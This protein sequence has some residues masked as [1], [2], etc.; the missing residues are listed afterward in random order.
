MGGKHVQ[1]GR[2]AEYP[3]DY[4]LVFNHSND[5]SSR[6]G[7]S[8]S[9]AQ[10]TA[11][12]LMQREGGPP[13]RIGFLLPVY[14]SLQGKCYTNTLDRTPGP[15]GLDASCCSTQRRAADAGR[16]LVGRAYCFCSWI[17]LGSSGQPYLLA[18]SVYPLV[19]KRTIRRHRPTLGR[20][21]QNRLSSASSNT[22]VTFTKRTAT[23]ALFISL[24]FVLRLFGDIR[25]CAISRS[26]PPLQA[27]PLPL[28]C[29]RGRHPRAQ[30]QLHSLHFLSR[31]DC[32]R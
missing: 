6:C 3:H 14:K 15:G 8:R 26:L 7:K 27:C 24:L 1:M 19:W 10:P 25:P 32:A 22:R 23:A 31:R 18:R 5:D 28:S 20:T 11:E 13:P 29:R 2:A 30:N 4:L 16:N 12:T 21:L 17:F 9:L